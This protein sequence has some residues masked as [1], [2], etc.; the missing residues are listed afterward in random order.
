MYTALLRRDPAFDGVFFTCVRTTGVF[1]RPTCR[2]RHPR[3]DNVEFVAGPEE[4]GRKGYR[5][6]RL[7]RPLDPPES[8]P[9][10]VLQLLSKSRPGDPRLTDR[11]VKS[12]GV[13]PHRVRA[14]FRRRFGVTFQAFQRSRRMGEALARLH[15]GGDSLSAAWESGYESSSGFR[16]AFSSQFGVPP[17][18]AGVLRRLVAEEIPTPLRPMVAVASER[19]VCLLEFLDRRALASELDRLRRRWRAAIVP[20]SHPHIS[21]LRAELEEYFRGERRRFAV[22]LDLGGTAFQQ[23]VWSRLREIPFGDTRSYAEVASQVGK[24]EAVRAIGQ[25]NGRNPVAIVVPCHRV[26][27]ADGS[28]SGYGGGLW[29]KRWLLEHERRSALRYGS[30]P[31]AHRPA[32]RP[33]GLGRG[34]DLSLRTPRARG[35][36]PRETSLEAP[37]I[38]RYG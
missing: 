31:S 33:K 14:Y 20:G 25:A 23:R 6:C 35:P 34:P 5:P 16:E 8:H 36:M 2:A 7:C 27:G 24:P 1:C 9:A 22:P 17:G 37:R 21:R 3:R 18:G 15:G 19:G 38:R 12:L 10:W 13:N 26:V 29:R 28:L 11:A 4:A 30:A 32:A